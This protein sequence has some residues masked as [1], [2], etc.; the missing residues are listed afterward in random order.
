M[1]IVGRQR[2]E[3]FQQQTVTGEGA[4]ARPIHFG[5][6]SGPFFIKGGIFFIS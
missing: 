2:V 5:G 1:N 6:F 3:T 4:R